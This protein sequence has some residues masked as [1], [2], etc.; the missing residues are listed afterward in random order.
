MPPR[1]KRPFRP[2]IPECGASP[3][4][5]E[6]PAAAPE[7]GS[8]TGGP[9]FTS[10]F[11]EVPEALPLVWHNLCAAPLAPEARR[12]CLDDD[13]IRPIQNLLAHF[14]NLTTFSL[15][16]TTVHRLQREWLESVQMLFEE[17][18][19]E[20][21]LHFFMHCTPTEANQSCFAPSH[22][23]NPPSLNQRY[24]LILMLLVPVSAARSL[25]RD[26]TELTGMFDNMSLTSRS[27]HMQLAPRQL[28]MRA[29]RA[30]L[31]HCSRE[32]A[33]SPV[34]V[35]ICEHK[36]YERLYW[37]VVAASDYR[38]QLLQQLRRP[39]LDMPGAGH[40]QPTPVVLSQWPESDSDES[41]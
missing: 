26:V 36:A 10:V 13:M 19:A 29:A 39:G 17:H 3:E 28:Y 41:D 37:I 20:F 33:R 11:S 24:Q 4:D 40:L 34:F 7:C 1:K 14:C 18:T 25:S 12:L 23:T 22:R 21:V 16:T 2:T 32:W 5:H 15:T 9:Q 31:I 6:P 30:G 27:L 35:T 8:Q 38:R